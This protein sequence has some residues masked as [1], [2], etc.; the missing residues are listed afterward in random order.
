MRW[1]VVLVCGA[2]LAQAPAFDVASVKVRE[3]PETGYGTER[4]VARPGTLTMSN[5]RMRTCIQWAYGVADYQIA[6][7]G[8]LGEPYD[9]R[10]TPRYDIAAKA[11][12]GASV[13]EM[14]AMLRTLLADRFR[15]ETHRTPREMA[16][17]LLS[18]GAGGHKLQ[19][20]APGAEFRATP[21]PTDLRLEGATLDEFG[22]LISGKLKLPVL[23]R[24][25]L[26]GRFD[27]GLDFS[28][29]RPP[30][31]DD[32]LFSR[33][34]REQLGLRVETKKAQIEMVV[35]DRVEKQPAAN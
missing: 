5:V 29:F 30:I 1:P 22:N 24:T 17:W 3:N 6:G 13:D 15:L 33:A 18:V 11:R 16:S 27:F 14:R 8:W 26:A 7:P 20:A 34:I 35:V 25:G 2:A 19:L 21:S 31:E 9:Y 12:R 4:V 32:E 23:N 10:M 28:R